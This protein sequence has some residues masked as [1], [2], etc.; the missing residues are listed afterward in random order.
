MESDIVA[1][2][3]VNRELPEAWMLDGWIA[4]GAI[5]L[6]ELLTNN[7]SY[8]VQY[9]LEKRLANLRRHIVYIVRNANQ[10]L[11]V[12]TTV[13]SARARLRWHKNGR[14]RLGRAIKNA[15][16]AADAWIVEMFSYPDKPSRLKAERFAIERLEPIFN[17]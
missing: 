17:E 9:K 7:R 15:K 1:T 11:Y 13:Y 6:G 10:V 8:P 3:E 5:T 16:Q 2:E 14:S 12:G 4:Y